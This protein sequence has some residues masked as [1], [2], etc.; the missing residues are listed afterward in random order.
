MKCGITGCI[1]GTPAEAWVSAGFMDIRGG[2]VE[3]DLQAMDGGTMRIIGGTIIG[4]LF[5]FDTSLITVLG[6]D[7]NLPLGEVAATPLCSVISLQGAATMPGAA[8]AGL[9]QVGL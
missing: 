2:L 6:S 3:T 8:A 4:D 9:S 5:A 7:F 1:T